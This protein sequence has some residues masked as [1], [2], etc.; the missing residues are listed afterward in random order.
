MVLFCVPNLIPQKT[1]PKTR[2]QNRDCIADSPLEPSVL[3]SYLSFNKERKGIG[4]R[5]LDIIDCESYKSGSHILLP[6]HQPVPNG[7]N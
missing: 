4:Q 2:P 6:T 5:V 3:R 7:I 1:Q